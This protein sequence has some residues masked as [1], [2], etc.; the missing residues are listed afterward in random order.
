MTR[1]GRAVP[2]SCTIRAYLAPKRHWAPPLRHDFAQ[3]PSALLDR[4]FAHQTADER[5]AVRFLVARAG[6]R[7]VREALHWAA[8]LHAGQ[9]LS[10]GGLGRTLLR[11]IG[12]ALREML[13]FAMTGQTYTPTPRGPTRELQLQ[14]Q[15]GRGQGPE[16]AADHANPRLGPGP[17]PRAGRG[18]V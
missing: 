4:G 12:G 11:E 6:N 16:P 2:Q 14:A 1:P 17:D 9:R 3:D 7:Q 8:Q 10:G 18:P 15:G 13:A 5:V